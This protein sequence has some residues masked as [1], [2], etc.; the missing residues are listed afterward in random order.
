MSDQDDYLQELKEKYIKDNLLL[1]AK[2]GDIFTDIVTND[3]KT[4]YQSQNMTTSINWYYLYTVIYV[5]LM[6]VFL[7]LIMVANSN[8]SWKIKGVIFILFIAYPFF[9][10]G[11]VLRII[12]FGQH[13]SSL[14]PKNIYK[15]L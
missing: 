7:A 9:A 6:L 8:Y 1:T 15:D 4:F 13:V 10:Y 14:L 5:L 3:R 12:G 2:I 11:I